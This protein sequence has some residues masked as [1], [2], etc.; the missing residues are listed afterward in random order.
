M[1]RVCW[2]FGGGSSPFPWSCWE[3]D[4]LLRGF[5]GGGR[6]GRGRRGK[7]AL[8]KGLGGRRASPG[9]QPCALGGNLGTPWVS[10]HRDSPFSWL[11]PQGST[12]FGST[13]FPGSQCSSSG[14]PKGLREE[15]KSGERKQRVGRER[16]GQGLFALVG[17]CPL[18]V[19][20]YCTSTFARVRARLL[21]TLHTHMLLLP[22]THAQPHPKMLPSCTLSLPPPARS[23]LHYKL[24]GD[25]TEQ[26]WL[27]A[28]SQPQGSPEPSTRA[29]LLP[30]LPPRLSQM[31][32]QP[33]P[34]RW[35]QTLCRKATS[36]LCCW[37]QGL[38][39]GMC[40]GLAA[41]LGWNENIPLPGVVFVSR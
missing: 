22:L 4:E 40:W 31:G 1:A 20:S 10:L 11:D 41:F 5:A 24:P 23:P 36:L 39:T 9:R 28:V 2:G 18:H 7:A 17:M 27:V 29:A 6:R 16:L 35:D 38:G 33:W 12:E 3:E 8:G 13:S 30:L 32:S 14:L 25:P 37:G 21:N 19:Y 26:R 34:A 15:R